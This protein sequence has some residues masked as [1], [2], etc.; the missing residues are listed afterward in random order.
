MASN[1]SALAPILFSAAQEVSAEAFGTVNSISNSFASKGVSKGDKVVVPVSPVQANTPFT[2]AATPPEGTSVTAGKVEVEITK[3]QKTS[4]VL[5]GEQ[6]RSLENGQNYQEFT[7]QFAAQG[8]RALRNECEIDCCNAIK[9]GA[10][11]AYGTAGTTPFATSIN[12]LANVRKILRDNGAPLADLQFV[13]NSNSELALLQLGIVQQ[14]FAAGSDMERRSAVLGRQ[15]G[16]SMNVSA[17]IEQHVKGTLVTTVSDLGATLPI[18]SLAINTDGSTGVD[19]TVKAGDVI[20]WAGDLNKYIVG[21]AQAAMADNT[22]LTLNRPGLRQ[23]LANEVTG[24]IGA[25]YTPNLAFERSAVV[26]IMRP[27]L[28]P[29]NPTM[30]MIPISDQFGMTYLFVEIAQYG[31]ITWE[32]HLAWGFKVVQPEHVALLLG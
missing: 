20:T 14:A 10:S 6:I 4:M 12:E 2:A 24:T 23:T 27:P 30:R 13:C 17:G 31:Q 26:G 8:M 22:I 19:G 15:L 25:S 32:I 1:I 3:S 5:T 9:E 7:R 21:I 29:A 18:G 16:F 28:M 11:R